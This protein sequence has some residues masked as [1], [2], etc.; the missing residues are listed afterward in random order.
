MGFWKLFR[1]KVPFPPLILGDSTIWGVFRGLISG[2]SEC[3]S[4]FDIFDGGF[5][6]EFAELSEPCSDSK[7]VVEAAT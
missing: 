2:V 3:D 6:D 7:C 5:E 4:G 1:A